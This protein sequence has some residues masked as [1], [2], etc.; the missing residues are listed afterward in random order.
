MEIIVNFVQSE[1]NPKHQKT[2]KRKSVIYKKSLKISK[3]QSESV[4]RRRTDKHN[5]Q[6][7]KVQ[8]DKQRSTK[9]TY[10]LYLH[11]IYYLCAVGV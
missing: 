7:K 3:R 11:N 1:I 5:G 4:Y 9:H 8:K 10:I 2:K 6:E